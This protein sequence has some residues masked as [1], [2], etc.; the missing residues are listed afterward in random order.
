MTYLS[1]NFTE[2]EMKCKGTSCCNGTCAMSRKTIKATE[3]VRMYVGRLKVNSGFRCNKH[4]KDV[5]GVID[6]FHPKGEAVDVEPL[7]ENVTLSDVAKYAKMFF[8]KVIVYKTFVHMADPK[9]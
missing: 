2:D 3:N 8:R 5:G 9:D 6:S 1:P 4:N 7:E